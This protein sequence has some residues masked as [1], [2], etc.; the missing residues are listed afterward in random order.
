MTGFFADYLKATGTTPIP[1]RFHRWAAISLV[2]AVLED[3]VWVPHHLGTLVPNLYVLLI[4]PSG[5]GKGTAI[6]NALA[7]WG[8][9]YGEPGRLIKGG[10]TK[11]NLLDKLGGRA[12]RIVG[13]QSQVA[14]VAANPHPWIVAPELYNALGSGGPVAEAFIANLTDLY[15]SSVMPTTEGTR[16][17]GTVTI[18]GHCINWLAGSTP[19]WLRRS[20]SQDAILSGFFGR[21]VTIEGTAAT[22]W[23]ESSYPPNLSGLIQACQTRLEKIATISGACTV[24]A[25]AQ[26]VRTQWL[27]NREVP[28]D[29]FLKP[30]YQRDDDL[31]MKLAIILSVGESDELV[32]DR[33]HI[34]K[35]R[36]LVAEA[37]TAL[38]MLVNL[39]H[40]TSQSDGLGWTMAILKR[41]GAVTEKRLLS[42]LSNRGI[43]ADMLRKYITTLEVADRITVKSGARGKVYTWKSEAKAF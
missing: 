40:T 37:R 5:C 15:T 36:T 3:R 23:E 31:L 26:A 11:Q 43:T 28:D 12:T 18:A 42:V 34:A 7:H 39:A 14:S 32:I 41:S 8:R 35:A 9:L 29:E 17:W 2:A 30:A 22:T 13:G 6:E 27:K 4:G 19:Q 1:E 10:L 20:L 16:Q 25:D 33:Q 24:T 38:P 21:V